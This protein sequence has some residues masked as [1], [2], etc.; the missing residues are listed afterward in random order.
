MKSRTS[1]YFS[2]NS[3][4]LVNPIAL[5]ASQLA[6]QRVS[7]LAKRGGESRLGRAVG[8]HIRPASEPDSD[9]SLLDSVM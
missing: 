8:R 7:Q 4:D 9:Y 3:G 6:S 5:L 1:A 2:V